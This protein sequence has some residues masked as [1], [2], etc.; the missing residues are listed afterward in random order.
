MARQHP[1]AKPPEDVFCEQ[2]VAF[3]SGVEQIDKELA[4]PAAA[5]QRQSVVQHRGAMARREP[6]HGVAILCGRLQKERLAVADVEFVEA[7]FGHARRRKGRFHEH[8]LNLVAGGQRQHCAHVVFILREGGGVEPVLA[9][10]LLRQ[11]LQEKAAQQRRLPQQAAQPTRW[12]LINQQFRV[13]V[14]HGGVP[15]VVPLDAEQHPRG[16]EC[17]QQFLQVAQHLAR[18]VGR[19]AGIENAQWHLRLPGQLLQ[20]RRVALCIVDAP[21]EGGGFTEGNPQRRFARLGRCRVPT[22]GRRA[23]APEAARIHAVAP[24]L[25]LKGGHQRKPA[26]RV[27][28][29]QRPAPGAHLLILEQGARGTVLQQP[30]AALQ[31]REQHEQHQGV[32]CQH[33][34]GAAQPPAGVVFCLHCAQPFRTG[35]K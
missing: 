21:A 9:L 18:A 3:G 22:R 26:L 11:W 29:H 25:A 14:E 17:G 27:G 30:R 4:G 1:A 24:V 33:A 16:L 19:H 12:L 7:L 15:D 13:P 10:R 5:A 35:Y 32:D 6:V 34:E 2:A 20:L 23:V 8:Q 31:H 28:G